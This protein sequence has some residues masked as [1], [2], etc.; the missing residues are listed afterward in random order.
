MDNDD[1]MMVTL[2]MEEE[3]VATAERKKHLN[4]S[5]HCS[6]PTG[7]AAIPSHL[8]FSYGKAEEHRP[9]APSRGSDA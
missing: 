8:R 6:M 9:Q 3:L 4:S 7:E 1:E 2:L 5:H